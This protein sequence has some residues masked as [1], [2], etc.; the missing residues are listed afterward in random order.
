MLGTL[1]YIIHILISSTNVFASILKFPKVPWAIVD[2]TLAANTKLYVIGLVNITYYNINSRDH[3]K[4]IMFGYRL[5]YL[6][7]WNN[8][9]I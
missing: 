4:V 5:L 7:E 3:V 2:F 6:R 9:F 8:E 1:L